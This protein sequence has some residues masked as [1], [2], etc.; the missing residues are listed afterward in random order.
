MF[1]AVNNGSFNIES[2]G[3]LYDGVPLFAESHITK[4]LVIS[5][6]LPYLYLPVAE[7][8]QIGAK[9]NIKYGSAI[10]CNY[11]GN[12]CRFTGD[13]ANHGSAKESLT[14]ILNQT[15]GKNFTIETNHNDML[16]DGAVF[17]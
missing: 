1:P 4:T 2:I 13:C 16:V 6:H 7:W 8:T 10:D 15:D 3:Q 5:P 12:Y 11:S 14:L 9:L 17:G